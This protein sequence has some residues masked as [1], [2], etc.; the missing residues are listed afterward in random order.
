MN[1]MPMTNVGSSTSAVKTIECGSADEFLDAISPRSEHFMS[2]PSSS[3][4]AVRRPEKY[5]FRGHENDDFSL[6]PSALRLGQ[7]IKWNQ[8]GRV[9]ISRN[10][11]Q[12]RLLQGSRTIVGNW[13]NRHQ[14]KRSWR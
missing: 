4:A 9:V 13:T 8:W 12:F 7:P 2:L 14:I 11:E 5:I 6:I 10:R 3:D 1:K